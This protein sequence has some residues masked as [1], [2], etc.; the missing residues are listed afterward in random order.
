[1]AEPVALAQFEVDRLSK[2]EMVRVPHQVWP[3]ARGADAHQREVLEPEQSPGREPAL[4]RHTPALS[5]MAVPHLTAAIV[6]DL[7]ARSVSFSTFHDRSHP[8]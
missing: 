1:M 8:S 3:D 6:A 7:R 4:A 2:Q 5:V